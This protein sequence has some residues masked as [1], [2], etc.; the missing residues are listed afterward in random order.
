[1]SAREIGAYYDRFWAHENEAAQ[2]EHDFGGFQRDAELVLWRFIR[3]GGGLDGRRL[4]EIG[5]GRGRDSEAFARAGARLVV[6][7]VS[8]RSVELARERLRRAGL[9]GRVEAVVADAARLPFRDGSFEVSF[10]RFTIA[11]IPLQP[12]AAELARVLRPGGRAL[13][14]EP[15]RD[16][17]LVRLYRRFAPTGCRETAPRYVSLDDLRQMAWHFPRGWR[18]RDLYLLS[19]PALA[20]RGTRLFGPVTAL[21]QAL[22]RPLTMWSPLR[23]FCWVVVAELRR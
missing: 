21:L 4:L 15:L 7:D 14:V 20:L 1:M 12:L 2:A 18:H 3:G 13:M 10:S 6:S 23:R 11:H 9:G 17:P 5:P 16:N 19:I 8:I 22:E